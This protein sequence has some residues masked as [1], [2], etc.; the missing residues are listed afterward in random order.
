VNWNDISG[1]GAT[2]E[3]FKADSYQGSHFFHN[4]TSLG[5]SYLTNSHNGSDFIDWK[6]L[7][8]LPTAEKIAPSGSAGGD[9]IIIKKFWKEAWSY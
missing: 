8:S 3:N 2:I 4:I 6:W 9:W 5:I 1:V 7:Q